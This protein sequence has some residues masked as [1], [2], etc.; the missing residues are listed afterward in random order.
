MA[1]EIQ[2]SAS[3]SKILSNR[4]RKGENG[5]RKFR[6][7]NTN[8]NIGQMR[9]FKPKSSD[10]MTPRTKG[11]KKLSIVSFKLRKKISEV[12]LTLLRDLVKELMK[13]ILNATLSAKLKASKLLYLPD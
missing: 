12:S 6:R 7:E 9:T 13:N 2:F 1:H 8:T 11:G 5:S 4:R 3:H 10:A